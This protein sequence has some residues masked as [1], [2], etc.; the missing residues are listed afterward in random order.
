MEIATK[1]LG[2]LE[3]DEEKIIQFP[4]GIPGFIKETKFVILDFPDNPI[5]QILQSVQNENIAFVITD[6][7]LIY[8]D[9]SFKL[10][11]T[12]LEVLRIESEKD[13]LVSSIV[14]IKNPFEHS[15]I[16]LKAPIIINPNRLLGK[17][18]I[19]NDEDYPSKATINPVTIESGAK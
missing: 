9:Y 19:L 2:I 4:N 17:Q 14:T 16:N 11:E 3:I 12:I 13:V 10:D 8:R 18:Y 6:P 5:F 15:T 7:Y 1:Y